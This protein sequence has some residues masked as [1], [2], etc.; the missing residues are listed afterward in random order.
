MGDLSWLIGV[1]LNLV[2][3]IMINAGTNIMK[4]G[5]NRRAAL[6]ARDGTSTVSIINP[7]QTQPRPSAQQSNPVETSS[8]HSEIELHELP[9]NDQTSN[10]SKPTTND[11]DVKLSHHSSTPASVH[12]V[13]DVVESDQDDAIIEDEILDEKLS[14]TQPD[15]KK[16]SK[17][18]KD[19]VPPVW[20]TPTWIIG[21]VMFIVG[22]CLNFASFAFA[23]QS[24]L[25][26]LGAI[27]FVS[28][29]IF[30]RFV[31][32]ERITWRILLATGLIVVCFF[33]KYSCYYFGFFLLGYR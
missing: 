10:G 5:H 2:G 4:L 18:K 8:H 28:N 1:G 29:V 12:E 11:K 26:S 13:D 17:K 20:K 9:A 22:N 16:S 33:F 3:S 21:L 23:A 27:Q 14:T 7:S 31:L 15:E 25:A 30:A 19:A 24:L 32:G 6:L